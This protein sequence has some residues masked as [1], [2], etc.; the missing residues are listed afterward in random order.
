MGESPLSPRIKVLDLYDWNIRRALLDQSR[1]PSH[2]ASCISTVAHQ[3]PRGGGH[4]YP[5]HLAFRERLPLKPHCIQSSWLLTCDKLFLHKSVQP[6][7][8]GIQAR[9][10]HPTLWQGVPQTLW[11]KKYFILSHHSVLVD[12][13]WFWYCVREKRISPYVY[14]L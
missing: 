10:H 4:S 13:P 5:L 6:T 8:K 1:S 3:M 7:F 11:V 9:H 12:T 2:P 14:S